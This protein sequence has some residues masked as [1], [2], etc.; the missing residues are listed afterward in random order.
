M[1]NTDE[2]DTKEIKIGDTQVTLNDR[3]LEYKNK[4]ASNFEF[5]INEA[6]TIVVSCV[7]SRTKF[8]F[9]MFIIIA[10]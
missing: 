5:R 3:L 1:E 2:L 9:D 8:I 4:F 6:G 10:G 7:I